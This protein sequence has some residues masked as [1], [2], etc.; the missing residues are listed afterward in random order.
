MA[1][2]EDIA[3]RFHEVY[4]ELAPAH[5]WKTQKRSAVPWEEIPIENRQLMIDVVTQLLKEKVI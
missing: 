1:R 2:A 5:G 3:R 4:E